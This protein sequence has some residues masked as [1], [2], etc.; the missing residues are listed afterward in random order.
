MYILNAKK[1]K[2]NMITDREQVP[3]SISISRHSQF[4][5]PLINA[6]PEINATKFPTIL[7]TRGIEVATLSQAACRKL[8]SFLLKE[9][10][11][12]YKFYI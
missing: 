10:Y 11:K 7:A 9:I 4:K 8:L 3:S 2:D 12:T 5:T 1:F 6:I